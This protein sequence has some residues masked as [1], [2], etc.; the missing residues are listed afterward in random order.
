[1]PP[2]NMTREQMLE[3]V[4]GGV[5]V[6]LSVCLFYIVFGKLM[7]MT[8]LLKQFLTFKYNDD[9]AIRMTVFAGIIFSA[10]MLK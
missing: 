9:F 4:S 3:A 10:A 2:Y 7:G 5:L 6:S 8:S 1:M